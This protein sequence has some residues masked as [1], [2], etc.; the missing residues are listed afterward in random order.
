MA[1]WK[2]WIAANKTAV[3]AS[4]LCIGY[5]CVPLTTGMVSQGGDLWYHLLRIENIKESIL[6]GQFPVRIGSLF[7]N[8]YGYASSL[9]YPEL[10]LYIPAFFRLLG[11]S[12][13]D[14]LNLFLALTVLGS[15]FA[16]F[17]CAK[18]ITKD[19]D[20]ALISAM[21]YSMSQYH[22]ANLF[23]RGSVGEAQA[24]VFFPLIVYGLYDLIQGRFE[25]PWVFGLGFWGLMFSHTISLVIALC[26]TFGL[27]LI[28]CKRV[29]VNGRKLCKLLITAAAVLLA[30]CMY[31]LPFIEQLLSVE[32]KFGTP[33]TLVSETAVQW[34]QIFS[35]GSYDYTFNFDLSILLLCLPVFVLPKAK[36]NEQDRKKAC[37]FLA[38]GLFTLFVCTRWFPWK[39]VQPVLNNL[40]FPWRF[41][42]I[43]SLFLSLAVGIMVMLKTRKHFLRESVLVIFVIMV[44][45]ATSF[46]ENH[47]L[48]YMELEQDY[49]K[50][51]Y[52]TFNVVQGEWLPKAVPEETKPLFDRRVITDA[53]EI[54][55]HN[56][57]K[58]MTVSFDRSGEE[59]YCDVPFI[60]YK[61]YQATLQTADGESIPLAVSQ[62]AD[63]Y[64]LV[65]VDFAGNTEA[66]KVVVT[67]GG[68]V[69]QHVTLWISLLTIVVWGSVSLYGW[70]KKRGS[71]HA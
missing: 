58:G 23:V 59:A 57:E 1:K 5:L 24:F 66:G 7:Y 35:V 21:V 9:C 52:T 34:N 71:A 16:C 11:V 51:T 28:Y 40:Q 13:A 12:I 36:E 32:M 15:F 65:K 53:G 4:V 30:S 33:W 69:I 38:L 45:G 70:K 49:F 44:V 48:D 41:Y 26:V 14:S 50:Q 25:K 10:F 39:L 47:P 42:A 22:I 2:N 61:G 63:N 6:D 8:G 3:I 68:T 54:L 29:I 37:W 55:L 18:Q 43:A 60:W 27:C 64:G 62:D 46:Y 56:E 17:W 67:Y 20:M 31:W 19:K